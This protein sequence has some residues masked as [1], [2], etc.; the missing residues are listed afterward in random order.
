MAGTL[1]KPS[2]KS[3]KLLHFNEI[4]IF[5]WLIFCLLTLAR[6]SHQDVP[7][8]LGATKYGGLKYVQTS[9]EMM[10]LLSNGTQVSFQG[11]AFQIDY[12]LGT[13][14]ITITQGNQ[15][16]LFITDGEHYFIVP[17]T[18]FPDLI[19]LD[20]NKKIAQFRN[21]IGHNEFVTD[22]YNLATGKVTGQIIP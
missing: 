2:I 1:E 13:P 19:S 7:A 4:V 12:F 17:G 9:A 14:T 10:I 11:D 6:T 20:F 18:S 5:C 16:Q 22:I 3:E 15:T 8:T 21:E